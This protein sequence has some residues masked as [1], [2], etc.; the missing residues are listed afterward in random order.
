MTKQVV[1]LVVCV[2][3][4]GKGEKVRQRKNEAWERKEQA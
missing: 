2:C 3:E 4:E 1:V